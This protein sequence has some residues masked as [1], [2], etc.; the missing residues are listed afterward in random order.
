MG[1]GDNKRTPKM[2]RRKA[3]RKLKTRIKRRTD[4]AKAAKKPAAPAAPK[5]K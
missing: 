5:K 3:Q 4:A 1:R 2:R